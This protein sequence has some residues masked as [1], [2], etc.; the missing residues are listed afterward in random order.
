MIDKPIDDN[1]PGLK[2]SIAM[3]FHTCNCR[4]L[5]WHVGNM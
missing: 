1:H 2:S 4:S 3:K 5:I